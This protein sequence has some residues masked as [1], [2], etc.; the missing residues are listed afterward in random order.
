MVLVHSPNTNSDFMQ[1]SD[2]NSYT[3][4]VPTKHQGAWTP[5]AHVSGTHIFSLPLPP[6]SPGVFYFETIRNPN[7]VVHPLRLRMGAFTSL[8]LHFLICEMEQVCFPQT[9]VR[10]INWQNIQAALTKTY[11]EIKMVNFTN[12]QERQMN[13]P[14]IYHFSSQQITEQP[15]VSISREGVLLHCSRDI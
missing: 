8:N 14:M 7:F 13:E 9:A 3:Q 1:S 4:M 10:M 11:T 6:V 5:S 2:L 12:N 15:S